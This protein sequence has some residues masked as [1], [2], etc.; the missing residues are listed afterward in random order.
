MPKTLAALLAI[1]LAGHV[2]LGLQLG[3]SVDEAHY[4]LYAL[5]PALSYFDHPPLVGWL[6]MPFVWLGGADWMMRVVPLALWGL[7]IYLL[8]SFPT[9]SPPPLS[10]PVDGRGG[11]DFVFYKESKTYKFL[12]IGLFLLGPIHQLL[13]LALIPDSLLLPL[14]LWVM[15]LTWRLS[16]NITCRPYWIWL[17]VALGL[18][19]LSKYTGLFLALGVALVLL[20]QY[21]ISLFKL[22]SLWLAVFIAALLISP[23]LVWNAQNDWV[24][25][26]YQLNHADGH[27]NTWEA[28]RILTYS[29]VQFMTYGLLPLLGL[30]VFLLTLHKN[31]NRLMRVCLAFGLPLMLVTLFLSGNGAALPHWT[32][33]AWLALLPLSALGIEHIWQNGQGITRQ[34]RR[35]LVFGLGVVQALAVGGLGMA[36]STGGQWQG[37]P[38][39]GAEHTS[40]RNPFAD[41]HDWQSAAKLASALQAEHKVDALAVS[42]WTL[43]S[44]LAWYTR[45]SNVLA[46]DEK[47]K[48]FDIWFGK[49]AYAQS[50]IW[51]DWSQM[52]QLKPVACQKLEGKSYQG[53]YSTFDFYRCGRV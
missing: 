42:N 12:L 32:A 37:K 48:Q 17:G 53:Q 36:M 47:N 33:N 9:H 43:A 14:T 30:V 22:P 4:A 40:A 31:H 28:K 51:M 15:V 41:M 24:S 23:V 10:R 49:L 20:P 46:L 25:F 39:L 19:G 5:H 2:W 16:S 44:R 35:A 27:T 52:P 29:L 45:P 8:F 7:T 18:A 26:A 50:Y 6:Q 21:G 13:G 34:A 1:S 3:L 38:F 11:L